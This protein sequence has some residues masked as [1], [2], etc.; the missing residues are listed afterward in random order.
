MRVAFQA[1][2]SAIIRASLC[3]GGCALGVSVGIDVRFAESSGNMN[4]TVVADAGGLVWPVDEIGRLAAGDGNPG[5]TLKNVVSLIQ[6][7]FE[8]DVCSVYLLEPGRSHL[9]LAATIGLRR[10]RGAGANAAGR[11]ARRAG[12][13]ATPAAD[14]RRREAAFAIQAFQR[15]G[16]RGVSVVPGRSAVRS[17]AARRRAGGANGRSPRVFAERN[18]H[19]GRRRQPTGADRR[20]S[21]RV[22]TVRGPDL[23]ATVYVGR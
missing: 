18:S 19:A 9:V 21:P 15:G 20:R 1:P 3:G 7:Q 13:A 4:K 14:G 16:R 10:E 8:T 11:G 22:G 23:S 5:Q 2:S 17:R 12:R 6:R